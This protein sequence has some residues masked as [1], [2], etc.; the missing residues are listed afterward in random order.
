MKNTAMI[1]LTIT[2]LILVALAVMVSYNVAFPMV[3]YITCAGQAIFI[4]T[5][6]KVLTDKYSTEKTFDD[7]YEDYP[8]EDK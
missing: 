6:Y 3:F 4:F 5:V 2:T 8:I 7:W 1:L